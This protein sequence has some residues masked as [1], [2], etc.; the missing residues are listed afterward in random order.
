MRQSGITSRISRMVSAKILAPPMLSSS[1]FTLVTTACFNPS[2][3]TASA[4]RRGSS[5][6]IASG[7]PLGTAQ[8]PQRRVQMLPSSMKVAVLWFQHSPMFGHCADSQT[9]CSPNPRASF[10]RLWKLSPT[11]ARAFSHPGLGVGIRGP[12]SIWMS[13]EEADMMNLYFISSPESANKEERTGDGRPPVP[14]STDIASVLKLRQ[15]G[16]GVSRIRRQED[17]LRVRD[18][19]DDPHLRPTLAHDYSSVGRNRIG[20]SDGICGSPA[21]AVFIRRPRESASSVRLKVVDLFADARIDGLQTSTQISPGQRGI[22]K[23]ASRLRLYYSKV[24][25][26]GVGPNHKGLVLPNQVENR[27]AR[28][29]GQG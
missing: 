22:G 23:A 12:S 5:Q 15:R 19:I 21:A 29:A 6:S 25:R 10:F 18:H 2:L 17:E 3:A 4:T 26:E 8:K 1:R 13:W 24:D 28:L 9:V 16:I 20:F 7:R 27:R 11:G 14:C